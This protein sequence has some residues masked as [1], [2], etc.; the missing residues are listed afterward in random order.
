M[1]G[2]LAL[3]D[4]FIEL[5]V[6]V[7]HFLEPKDLVIF[8]RVQKKWNAL[9]S[10]NEIWWKHCERRWAGKFN[11]DWTKNPERLVQY[12]AHPSLKGCYLKAEADCT[13]VQITVKELEEFKWRFSFLQIYGAGDMYAYPKFFANHTMVMNGEAMK[14]KFVNS[15]MIQVNNYPPLTILRNKEDWSWLLTNGFVKFQSLEQIEV[16]EASVIFI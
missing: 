14:W 3:D 12:Q 2:G 9:S 11:F 1:D 8:A 6:C 10:S 16:Q 15:Y 5:L 4:L 7:I 13:R